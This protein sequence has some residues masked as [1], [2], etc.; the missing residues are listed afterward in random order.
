MDAE[1]WAV[2]LIVDAS[3][4]HVLAEAVAG[5]AVR[6]GSYVLADKFVELTIVQE[7]VPG[8]LVV[9]NLSGNEVQRIS[10]AVLN[11]ECAPLSV[12]DAV[13]VKSLRVPMRRAR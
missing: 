8:F 11:K 12:G 5:L 1:T 3:D 6:K 13:K 9:T 10:Y 4:T 7:G 2:L